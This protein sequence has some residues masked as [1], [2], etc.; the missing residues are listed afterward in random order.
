M[1]ASYIWRLA[2]NYFRKIAFL[3]LMS[4]PLI[5]S[6][7]KEVSSPSNID[8]L[9]NEIKATI[10][11]FLAED[12][13][14]EH[15]MENFCAIAKTNKEFQE[16]VS[17]EE[18]S[19]RYCKDLV[20]RFP[21]A[22]RNNPMIPGLFLSVF[23]WKEN[24]LDCIKTIKE[25]ASANFEVMVSKN[26]AMNEG[27]TEFIKAA[28]TTIPALGKY[29]AK[30]YRF[31]D[32]QYTALMWA[33]LY[34][35]KKIV[36]KLLNADADLEV[37]TKTPMNT[38]LH[39]ASRSNQAS[40]V[41]LLLQRGAKVDVKK[42]DL[43]T[44]L[45][46]AAKNGYAEVVEML[47][48]Y[49]ADYTCNDCLSEAYTRNFTCVIE[50]IVEAEAKEDKAKFLIGGKIPLLIKAIN[51]ERF[52]VMEKLLKAGACPNVQDALGNTPLIIAI[53][54]G[55]LDKVQVLLEA[56]ADPQIGNT[57][58]QTALSIAKARKDRLCNNDNIR[59]MRILEEYMLHGGPSNFRTFKF[60]Y[61]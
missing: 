1:K 39:Y 24:R 4:A 23:S 29:F 34:G 30:G 3:V 25:L 11:G 56:G 33:C 47:L 60:Q 16:I 7:E 32:E 22:T 35:H 49:Q 9:P 41:E 46:L 37:K 44:P 20:K 28:V 54:Q 15:A 26:Q 52:S 18:L 14:F 10:V 36:E 55:S 38:A 42:K 19:S 2:M 48:K 59:I 13:A 5:K 51:Y 21:E 58:G 43:K 31:G 8:V 6:M 12:C 61:Y 40:I 27:D 53:K 57:D 45:M 17:D 50:K